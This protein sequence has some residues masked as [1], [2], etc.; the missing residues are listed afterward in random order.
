MKGQII[1]GKFAQIEIRQKS[2][3]LLEIGDL[4]VVDQ[5]KEYLILQI[6]DLGYASQIPQ[7]SR[8]LMA[9]FNLEGFGQELE[10]F[11]PELRNYIIAYSKVLAHVK[12]YKDIITKKEELKVQTPKVLPNFFHN[13]RMID[14]KDLKFFVKPPDPVYFGEV[15]SGSKTLNV[16]VWLKG[17]E[18]LTHHILISATTGRGKSNFMKI[19]LWDMLPED[20]FGILVIDPHDEY[21]GR[22]GKGLKDHPEAKDNLVYYSPKPPGINGIIEKSSI[23][24]LKTLTPNDFSGIF[25]F[26]D[27][28][29]DAIWLYYREY[30]ADWIEKIV[31]EDDFLQGVGGGTISVIRRKLRNVLGVSRD[32][33]GKLSALSS[34]FKKGVMGESTISDIVNSLI[35]G[36]T[37]IIDTSLYRDKLELLVGSMICRKVFYTYQDLKFK[38]ELDENPVISI[39]IE[40]APRVLGVDALARGENIY[41]TIAKEGRKFNIGLI[42]ITQLA[43]VIPRTILANMNTKIILGNELGAERKAIIDSASQDL[44]RDDRTIASLD[45]GE[46][47]ISSNFTKF[48]VPVKFP[49]FED[50]VKEYIKKNRSDKRNVRPVY[51]G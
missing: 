3:E 12:K 8:E 46:A 35:C 13:V 41:S 47:I 28:Q 48:A 19:M 21:Y 29:N 49:L 31:L 18:V 40:E 10:F 24:N 44:S 32:K 4:L 7:Q 25:N 20:K 23:I 17:H 33:S 34:T 14:E 16:E 22:N 5:G 6:Y 2:D 26:S 45:K 30:K 15:R 38:G 36:K 1:S 37:V 51:E 11:E 50:L 9:G 39:V 43:S 42:G 27:A